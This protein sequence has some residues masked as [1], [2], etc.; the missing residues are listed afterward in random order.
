MYILLY[1]IFDIIFLL[2]TLVVSIAL[3][4]QFQPN[5]II[6]LIVLL[7]SRFFVYRLWF[8]QVEKRPTPWLRF[9][10]QSIFF[11]IS[12]PIIF[13][14]SSYFFP[15]TAGSIFWLVVVPTVSIIPF[16]IIHSSYK[17]K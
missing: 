8:V 5:P 13:A 14:L 17:I 10:V 15:S 1:S 3:G 12:L 9:T 16:I 4:S 2:F 6:F 7:G 11:L